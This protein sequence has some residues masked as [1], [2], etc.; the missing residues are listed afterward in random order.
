[1][2]DSSSAA[3]LETSTVFFGLRSRRFFT[4]ITCFFLVGDDMEADNDADDPAN[5]SGRVGC[6]IL[7]ETRVLPLDPNQYG[8]QGRA[9]FGGTSL[10][11]NSGSQSR[12][13][14]PTQSHSLT[15]SLTHTNGFVLNESS[16]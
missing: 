10:G 12:T 7:R 13:H 6:C 11:S 4:T 2:S 3:L 16:V 9:G 1:V 14:P 15:H 8:C 5:G